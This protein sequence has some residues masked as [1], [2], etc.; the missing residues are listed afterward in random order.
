[1]LV[2]GQVVDVKQKHLGDILLFVT[3]LVA[4]EQLQARP[5]KVLYEGDR[6]Q[7]CH[8]IA[9]F[10]LQLPNFGLFVNKGSEILSLAIVLE[11][12]HVL[13]PPGQVLIGGLELLL[14][15]NRHIVVDPVYLGHL[16]LR[17]RLLR[18][19]LEGFGVEQERQLVGII[20]VADSHCGFNLIYFLI[21]LERDW[22]VLERCNLGISAFT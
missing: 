6:E 22:L 21:Q 9:P 3:G 11:V 10:R 17:S 14:A 7:T 20:I 2:E 4:H 15:A 13:S 5:L 12:K 16:S 18:Q 8:S 1:M 19:L